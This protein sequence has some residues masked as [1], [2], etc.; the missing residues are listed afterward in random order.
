MGAEEKE[1]MKT[2]L[3]WY[4]TICA[5]AK[6]RGVDLTSVRKGDGVGAFRASPLLELEYT[7]HEAAHVFVLNRFKLGSTANWDTC[8]REGLAG[9][10]DCVADEMEMHT[11]QLTYR[12]GVQ[13][14]WWGEEAFTPIAKAC[15]R[16]LTQLY[17]RYMGEVDFLKLFSEREVP[18]YDVLPFSIA[19][20]ECAEEVLDVGR[21]L[22][23]AKRRATR[24]ARQLLKEA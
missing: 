14:G 20:H 8:I 16:N 2:A 6:A 4:P 19:I 10:S 12:A 3:E 13:L 5:L 22:T 24:L 7:I 18:A 21:T 1:R 11:A 9:K 17:L 23:Q 15:Q